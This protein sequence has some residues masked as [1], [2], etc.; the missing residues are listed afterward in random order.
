MTY[1]HLGLNLGTGSSASSSSSTQENIQRAQTTRPTSSQQLPSP[2]S[3]QVPGSSTSQNHTQQPNTHQP[4]SSSSRPTSS[5]VSVPS[6]ATPGSANNS[7]SQTAAPSSLSTPHQA[8]TTQPIVHQ[9]NAQQSVANP[10]QPPAAQ[11][12]ALAQPDPVAQRRQAE[13]AALQARLLQLD[14]EEA[15]GAQPLAIAPPIPPLALFADPATVEQARVAAAAL[16]IE[17]KK[18]PLPDLIPGFKANPLN[19]SKYLPLMHCR[20]HIVVYT[21]S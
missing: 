8:N 20:L 6:T 11:V 5:S 12:A 17:S 4:S 19:A 15:N 10:Q 9:P 14:T 2:P 1:S 3:T 16:H 21:P 18:T 13:R 7:T